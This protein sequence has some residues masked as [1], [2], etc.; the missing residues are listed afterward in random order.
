RVRRGLR[1]RCQSAE[2]RHA[3]QR[4]R[5]GGIL[6]QLQLLGPGRRSP[7]ASD[8]GIR[9]ARRWAGGA[10][11][12]AAQV[13]S[14][15]D[16]GVTGDTAHAPLFLPVLWEVLEGR[17]P[18][19]RATGQVYQVPQS[20]CVAPLAQ[21]LTTKTGVN[22]DLPTLLSGPAAGSPVLSGPAQPGLGAG[23]PGQ[24]V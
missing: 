14:R 19:R 8:L 9:A 23:R 5:R 17:E 11:S 7:R 22:E 3:H 2:H 10:G 6:A 20:S 12:A 21:L 13:G 4:V 18:P 1:P 15:T 24:E 16:E